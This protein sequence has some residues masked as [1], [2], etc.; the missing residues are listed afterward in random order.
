MSEAAADVGEHDMATPRI[1]STAVLIGYNPGG[2]C[3]YSEILDLSNYYDGEHVWDKGASVKR[4]KLQRLK[5]YFFDSD[6]NLDQE[7]ERV[8]DLS[9]G[10][11]KSVRTRFVDG[12]ERIDPASADPGA[13]ADGL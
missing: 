6:G 10:C 13:G 5:G 11:F 7:F 12:T 8:L 2:R 9:T 1:K 3:V 4:L